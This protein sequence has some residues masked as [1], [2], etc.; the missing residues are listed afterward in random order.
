MSV[1]GLA[2][3][4]GD[5]MRRTH[6]YRT[7]FA[8]EDGQLVLRDLIAFSGLHANPTAGSDTHATYFNLGMQRVVRRIAAF[9]NMSDAELLRLSQQLEEA[10]RGEE[11][12]D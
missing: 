1:R 3:K 6:A 7:L 8:S 12:D 4:V 2:R 9:T 5:L 10:R 11:T